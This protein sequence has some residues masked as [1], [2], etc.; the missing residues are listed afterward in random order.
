MFSAGVASREYDNVRLDKQ[1]YV[2]RIK[3]SGLYLNCRYSKNSNSLTA[4]TNATADCAA[5]E[6]LKG[7]SKLTVVTRKF[8]AEQ[9]EYAKSFQDKCSFEVVLSDNIPW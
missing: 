1:E 3:S 7:I 5:F 8:T 4:T 6:A 2:I 9:K